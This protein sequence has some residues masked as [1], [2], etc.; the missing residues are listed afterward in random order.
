[1]TLT[2]ERDIPLPAKR[3]PAASKWPFERMQP[4]ESVLIPAAQKGAA[5]TAAA[6]CAAK[7][8]WRFTGETTDGGD[9][10]IWRVD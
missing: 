7:L 1:M 4:G 10:R 2:I 6:K 8:A 9:L 3:E 5:R